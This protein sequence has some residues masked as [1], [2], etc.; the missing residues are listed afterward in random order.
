MRIPLAILWAVIFAS[1]LICLSVSGYGVQMPAAF[2]IPS[3][4]ENVTATVWISAE[5]KMLN[6]GS[7]A[8][9]L[10][11]NGA[12]QSQPSV[13]LSWNSSPSAG[14]KYNIYRSSAHSECFKIKSDDCKKVNLSPVAG[15]I[16]ADN[17]VQGGQSYF[18]VAR[19]VGPSGK[20][21]SPSNEAQ[22]MISIP[23]K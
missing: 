20:E 7:Q 5:V 11:R 4:T 16:Y 12:P 3:R 9:P 23:K 17:A 13:N 6:D 1:A 15:T 22:V 8:P 18:Y 10:N 21:S 19:A 2:N 14:V